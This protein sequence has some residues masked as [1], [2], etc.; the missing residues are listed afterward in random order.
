[1]DDLPCT[2]WG[3]YGTQFMDFFNA[4]SD[5]GPMFIV[6]KHAQIKEPQGQYNV[7]RSSFL[8]LVTFIMLN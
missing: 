3:D 1:M 7:F 8:F 6:I 5:D 4:K 2:L